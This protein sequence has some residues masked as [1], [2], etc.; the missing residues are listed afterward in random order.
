M[1]PIYMQDTVAILIGITSLGLF[2][3][4]WLAHGYSVK[5][6]SKLT[7]MIGENHGLMLFYHGRFSRC[8]FPHFGH[9]KSIT[10]D[11]SQLQS[12]KMKVRIKR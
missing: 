3:E 10:S 6:K 7:L 2:F 11:P 9:G 5:T 1:I 8:F 12:N 4:T